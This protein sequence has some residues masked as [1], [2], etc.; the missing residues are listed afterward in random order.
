M[1]IT[2]M[3]FSVLDVALNLSNNYFKNVRI[4]CYALQFIKM[5]FQRQKTIFGPI[6]NE[7]FK[8]AE[9]YFI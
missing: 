4:F 5:N 3:S 9:N 1:M 6:T 7:E 8:I 2:E